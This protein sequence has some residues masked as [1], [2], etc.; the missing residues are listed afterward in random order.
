V[1]AD[2]QFLSGLL[3]TSMTMSEH[4]VM[5]FEPLRVGGCASGSHA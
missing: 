3:G 1:V 4:A 5:D 2:H